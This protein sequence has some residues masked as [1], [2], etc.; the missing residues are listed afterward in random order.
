MVVG[1]AVVVEVVEAVPEV[2]WTGA[3]GAMGGVGLEGVGEG[4]VVEW[5]GGGPVV[6]EVLVVAVVEV[7]VWV[8]P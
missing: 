4:V 3:M 8:V 6:V 2:G 5:D 7:E 1:G